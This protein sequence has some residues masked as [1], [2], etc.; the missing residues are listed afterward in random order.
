MHGQH[1]LTQ[2]PGVSKTIAEII[3]Q[4]IETGTCRKF[5][6]WAHV[7]PKTVL[8]LTKIERL[9][10]KTAR[11]LYKGY[12]IDSLASLAGAMEA[13]KVDRVKG[14]GAKMKETIRE[15]VADQSHGRGQAAGERDDSLAR[16]IERTVV[17]PRAR[18]MQQVNRVRQV[19]KGVG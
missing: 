17:R 16:R 10:A 4:Y 7:T 15:G 18:L 6:Q 8:E 2:I 12:G 9:G 19:H 1:R 14:I 5:E 11:I 3:R 13:G